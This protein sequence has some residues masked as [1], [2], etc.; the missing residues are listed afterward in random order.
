MCGV[1]DVSWDPP[2]SESVDRPVTGYQIQVGMDNYSWN[3][4]TT[5]PEKH[6][7]LFKGLLKKGKYY[8]R[9]RAFNKKGPSDW[10]KGLIAASFS[11]MLYRSDGLLNHAH[12]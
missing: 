4:C 3:N 6:S 9:V 8:V 2:S 1:F 10:S 7:C 11:G 5:T 12:A